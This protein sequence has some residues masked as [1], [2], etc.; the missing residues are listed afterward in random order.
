MVTTRR[1]Q[2]MAR[3]Q[4]SKVGDTRV[5]P[6]GYHYTR[7]DKEWRLTHHLLAEKKLG[8]LLNKDERVIFVDGKRSNLSPDNLKVI[9][10]GSGSVAR[11]RARLT[12]RINE[13]T[14][15]L[16]ELT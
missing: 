13:L 7:T 4:S 14:A 6:N 8:R 1:E 3:G 11:Q 12:A 9:V 15:Q 10:K 2:R 5:S 16:N